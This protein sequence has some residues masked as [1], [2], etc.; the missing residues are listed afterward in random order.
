MELLDG[1][2]YRL[3]QVA[4]VRGREFST[5][6]IGHIANLP[7]EEVESCFDELARERQFIEKSRAAEWPDGVVAEAYRFVHALYRE[8]LYDGASLTHRIQTHKAMA[9]FLETHYLNPASDMA[10]ELGIHFEG[11]RDYLRAVYYLQEA[12]GIAAKRFANVEAIR[13]LRDALTLLA[14][15]PHAD[16]AEPE[17]AVLDQ[18][19]LVYQWLVMLK[20]AI[21]SFEQCLL[22][23]RRIG[24]CDLETNALLRLSGVLFWT[25]HHR[26]LET[27]ERAVQVSMEGPD[28]GGIGKRGGI[29]PLVEWL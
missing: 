10:S 20:S 3:L 28:R 7:A 16:R 4:S 23:S 9:G 29:T 12:A 14:R 19:G 5:R 6:E 13:H 21:N 1:K 18:L 15:V 8:V 27:A 11:G 2:T 22:A 24:R 17:A 25:D 26:S